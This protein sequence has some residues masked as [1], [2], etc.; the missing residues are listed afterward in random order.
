MEIELKIKLY[1]V[2]K[3]FCV[4]QKGCCR[5]LVDFHGVYLCRLFPAPHS[6][7]SVLETSKKNKLKI[8]KRCLECVQAENGGLK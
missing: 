7:L 8:P 6:L 4:F 3:C 1:N 2:S 5:Y